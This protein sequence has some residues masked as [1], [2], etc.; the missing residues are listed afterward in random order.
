MLRYD[1]HYRHVRGGLAPFSLGSRKAHDWTDGQRPEGDR[2]VISGFGTT[3]LG[4]RAAAGLEPAHT[5]R[6]AIPALASGWMVESGSSAPEA[7]KIASRTEVVCP[8][9]AAWE[10]RFMSTTDI[11]LTKCITL[12]AVQ[13]SEEKLWAPMC[14]LG[15]SKTCQ[16]HMAAL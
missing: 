6:V 8:C 12:Q 4:A 2:W 3:R 15:T 1:G 10:P 13:K 9:E 7:G 5:R 11:Q 14:R 16:W